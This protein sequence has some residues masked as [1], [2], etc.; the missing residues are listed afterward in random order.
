MPS[1]DRIELITI[2]IFLWPTTCSV[3]F[4]CYI[5]GT[6]RKR[7]VRRCVQSREDTV[8]LDVVIALVQIGAVRSLPFTVYLCGVGVQGD[9][10]T[11]YISDIL[12]APIRFLIIPD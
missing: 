3:A 7:V 11:A 12:G 10:C 8:V 9:P 5:F 1:T 4:Q 2:K 6:I